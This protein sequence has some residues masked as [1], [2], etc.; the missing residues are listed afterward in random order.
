[1]KANLVVLCALVISAIGGAM[2]LL[3]WD[4]VQYK[5]DLYARK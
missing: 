4:L 1:M 3:W 2:V 5:E